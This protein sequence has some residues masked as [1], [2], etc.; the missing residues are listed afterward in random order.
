MICKGER[1]QRANSTPRSNSKWLLYA[2]LIL[3]I[4]QL[5]SSIATGYAAVELQSEENNAEAYLFITPPSHIGK[6]IGELF[7]LSIDI[8]SV[9]DLYSLEFSVAYNNT[10]LDVAEVTQGTFLPAPPR[11]DFTYEEDESIGLIK[12]IISLTGSETPLSGNGALASITFEVI[13]ASDS[14][15]AVPIDLRQTAL[16]DSAS[17]RILHDSVG[18]VYFWRSMQPDPSEEGRLLDLYTQKGGKGQSNPD[19]DFIEGE[20]VYLMSNVTYSGAP[21]CDKLVVF[22]ARNP[23]DETVVV[24]TAF[25]D[26]EGIAYVLFSIPCLRSSYGTWTAISRVDIAE[27]GVWDVLTFEVHPR[28]EVGGYTYQS[29]RH[30]REEHLAPYMALIAIFT[31]SF[32]AVK[33]KGSH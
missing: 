20:Q 14:C 25:T 19:G 8:A 6:E 18:A 4:T 26:E 11:S 9:Q 31:A 13:S 16:L 10:V 7:N 32:L 5:L 27:R 30:K 28:P 17:M 3:L 1:M 33:R 23:L 2:A 29:E 24:R 22:E 15:V 21:V 12:V